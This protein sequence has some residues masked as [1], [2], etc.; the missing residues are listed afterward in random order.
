[1]DT[2]AALTLTARHLAQ[3]QSLALFQ[4]AIDVL[5]QKRVI[6]LDIRVPKRVTDRV[7]TGRMPRIIGTM[8]FNS[9]APCSGSS[10]AMFTQGRSRRNQ[11]SS[12][13]RCN[14]AQER[15]FR[16]SS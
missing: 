13:S 8:L 15:R 5:A 3:G 9:S 14:A 12:G 1:M 16:T 6:A 4:F 7:K 2:I 10:Y 11:L